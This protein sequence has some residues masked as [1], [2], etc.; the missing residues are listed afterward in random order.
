MLVIRFKGWSVKLDHQVGGAGKFGIWSF[1]GSESSYVPDMETILRHAAIRP[2]EPKEGA[3]VEVLIC[4][5]RMPQDEWR[6]VGTG[7]AAYEAER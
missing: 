7:V 4:D 2:A 3:E 6:A 5:S 1:H